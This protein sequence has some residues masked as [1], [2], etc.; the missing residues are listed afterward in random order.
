MHQFKSSPWIL[1]PLEAAALIDAYGLVQ[2]NSSEQGDAEHAYVQV[3]WVG[4]EHVRLPT[5]GALAYKAPPVRRPRRPRRLGHLWPFGFRRKPEG[6]L[7]DC[8]LEGAWG[9][10]AQL[11][12]AIRAP[13]LMLLFMVFIPMA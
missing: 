10:V 12:L 3:L 11:V 7:R 6:A 9:E 4:R 13:S 5:S 1:P 2:D 8:D